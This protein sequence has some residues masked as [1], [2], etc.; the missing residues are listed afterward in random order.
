MR[1]L[2]LTDSVREFWEWP[3]RPELF[4]V[5]GR[6]ITMIVYLRERPP[7]AA[8]T[9][10]NKKKKKKHCGGRGRWTSVNHGKG[11][12]KEERKNISCRCQEREKTVQTVRRETIG[13]AKTSLLSVWVLLLRR[14]V[15]VS[16][17]T[18]RKRAQVYEEGIRMAEV[19]LENISMT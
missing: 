5:P 12:R 14:M 19:S 16:V 18:I 2:V 8:G 3:R 4:I 9:G 11:D 13:F 6:Q 17:Y 15:E 10:D 1:D 7:Q